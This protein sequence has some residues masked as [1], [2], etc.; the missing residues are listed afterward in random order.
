MQEVDRRPHQVGSEDPVYLLK[1]Q[2]YLVLEKISL[3]PGAIQVFFEKVDHKFDKMDGKINRRFE[4]TDGKI[5]RLAYFFL[6]G[7]VLKAGSIFI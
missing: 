2:N 1:D 6:G 5:D 7:I 3:R 4:R